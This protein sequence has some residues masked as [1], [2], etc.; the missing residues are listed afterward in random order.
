MFKRFFIL[1]FLTMSLGLLTACETAEERAQVHYEKGVALLEQGDVDRALVEF[2]N[3]FK[4]NGFH[5]EARLAY[6]QA[7]EDRGDIPAAYGQYLRLIEQYPENLTGRRALARLASERNNWKEVARHLKVAQ[8]L[9]PKDP[10]ILAMRA[11]LDYRNA[12]LDK[13]AQAAALVVRVAEALL[14]EDPGLPAARRVVIDD[15]LRQQDLPGAL[16]AIDEGLKQAPDTRMMYLQRLSVLENLGQD[17]AIEAQLKDMVQRFPE[18]QIYRTLINW[19]VS[20]DRRNDAEAY[21]RERIALEVGDGIV[22]LELVGFLAQHSSPQAA[23]DEIARILADSSGEGENQAQNRAL[24][25]S[26]RAGLDFDLG[27]QEAGIIEM[28]DILKDAPA[29]DETDKIKIAL[30]KMLIRTGN[31]VGARARVEEVLEHDA[32]Q[33][34]ALKMKAGWL[35]EDDQTGDALLELRRVLDQTPRDADAITLMALAHE[36]AG[37]RDLMGEMLALAVEASSRAPA[38]T[39]RYVQF[40][41]TDKKYLP[42]E[43]VLQEALRLKSTNPALLGALGNVYVQMKDWGRIQGVIDRLEQIGTDQTRNIA[44][45]LTARKLASQDRNDELQAFLGGLTEGQT[46]LQASASIIRLRLA[47]GDVSGALDYTNELLKDDPDN[48]ALR[49]IRGGVLAIDGKP[50]QAITIFRALVSED[51][52][53]ERIWLALYNLHRSQGNIDEATKLLAEAR[54]ALP[55]SANLKWAAAGEAEKNGDIKGA[56]AIY[57]DLYALNSNSLVIA[58]N[59]A[60]LI[61][62]YRDDDESLRR[63]FGIARRL[64]GT[65]VAPFQ[66]TY[67]WIAHRMGNYQEALSYLEP[68]AKA[69]AGDPVAQ[70]HLAQNYVALNR[71]AEALAQ[72]QKVVELVQLKEQAGG[73]RPPF[74]DKVEAEIIR[75]SAAAD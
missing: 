3:V 34:D 60:S 11:G 33:G 31:A 69:L 36:R 74:M 44:N 29:S 48:R 42:A 37:N 56:I 5:K 1:V 67:G 26:V 70:F 28:E 7:E 20:N 39:L 8:E 64:R 10:A 66:D 68:A 59:L 12:L 75:L 17:D 15:R 30:A 40:L 4:L 55:Q 13:N 47:Q 62:S 63:A 71:D 50:G 35:I 23:L 25:R 57:E 65:K 72:F 19:Y 21:L 2:R 43:A 32:T 9:A 27:N 18:E 14:A 54:S 6:A 46:G 41:L 24:F 52:N 58:N 51:A 38:Q 45:E 16:A 49:F 22:Q 73:P 61:T 53:D